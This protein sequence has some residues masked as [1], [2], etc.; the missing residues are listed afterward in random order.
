M[1]INELADATINSMVEAMNEAAPWVRRV[2]VT[3]RM[4]KPWMNEDV[5]ERYKD[6]DRTYR[7]AIETGSKSD[8]VEGISEKEKTMWLR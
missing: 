5:K 7:R 8:S 1:T 4:N 6:R 2:I 3:K